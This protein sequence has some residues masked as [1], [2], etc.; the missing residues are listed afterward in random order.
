LSKI[1]NVAPLDIP[2]KCPKCQEL[3]GRWQARQRSKANNNIHVQDV[4][5]PEFPTY[6]LQLALCPRHRRAK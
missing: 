1:K 5:L 4:L 3:S 2:Y 6:G